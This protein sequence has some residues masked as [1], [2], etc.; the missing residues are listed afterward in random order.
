MRLDADSS[1]TIRRNGMGCLCLETMHL[2]WRLDQ[3]A[4]GR[5]GGVA[6]EELRLVV[7]EEN[8]R[9]F[10]RLYPGEKI[11]YARPRFADC[12]ECRPLSICLIYE[13]MIHTMAQ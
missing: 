11:S 13:P 6:C 7:S 8:V 4:T 12:T 10:G 9:T 1:K 2:R 3:V 5:A